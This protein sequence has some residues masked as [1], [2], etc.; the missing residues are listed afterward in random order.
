MEAGGKARCVLCGSDEVVQVSDNL[1]DDM[2]SN[3]SARPH[4]C[5]SCGLVFLY[6]YMGEDEEK[7]FYQETFRALYHGKGYDLQAFHERGRAEAGRRRDALKR[8]GLLRGVLLEIGSATG[9]FLE[10]AAGD[11]DR[12]IGVEPDEAQRDF[13]RQRGMDVYGATEEL[14]GAKADIIVMFHVLE[15]IGNPVEFVSSLGGLLLP[16]GVLVAEVPNVSDV[17]LA[18]YAIPEFEKFYW[19]VA[20]RCYFSRR[21]L[22]SVAE[23]AGFSARVEPIQRYSLSNHLHWAVKGLPGGQDWLSDL[24]SPETE[25]A[26]AE[27][28]CRNFECDTLWLVA[29][30]PSS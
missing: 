13:A 20:H 14:D 6:P 12:C 16:G 29:T 9:Y 17:L 15:H 5:V 22:L 30:K 8:A 23:M 18:R 11:V 1:R 2:G 27:D 25:K 28:L 21:T 7:R 4:R 24:L 10:A 26:Y 3:F 19:H